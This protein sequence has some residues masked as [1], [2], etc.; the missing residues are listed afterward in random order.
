MGMFLRRGPAP[1]KP[2]TVRLSGTFDS[3]YCYATIGGTK[4]TSSATLTLETGVTVEIYVSARI[5]M[6][7]DKNCHVTLNGET[8]QRGG[9][10]YTLTVTTDTSIVFATGVDQSYTYGTC[11]ITTS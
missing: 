11:A 7:A 10:T 4:Y 6:A 9:G 5:T 2:V 3:S 1:A 8:V